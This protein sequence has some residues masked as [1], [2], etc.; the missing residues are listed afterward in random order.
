[1]RVVRGVAGRGVDIVFDFTAAR[2][3]DVSALIALARAGA[4][5]RTSGHDV[6]VVVAAPFVGNLVDLSGGR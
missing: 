6:R 5:V 3:V 2:F 4:Q 1:M